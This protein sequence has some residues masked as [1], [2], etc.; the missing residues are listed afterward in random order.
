M[1]WSLL[2]S[3]P[4]LAA[5]AD[6]ATTTHSKTTNYE[7]PVA[8]GSVLRRPIQKAQMTGISGN[9]W[10]VLECQGPPS[11]AVTDRP[12]T[13]SRRYR[14][15][16]M[17]PLEPVAGLAAL[18]GRAIEAGHPGPRRTANNGQRR[19]QALQSM[20]LVGCRPA[21]GG[22][23][24]RRVGD[25]AA[26]QGAPRLPV[27]GHGSTPGRHRGCCRRPVPRRG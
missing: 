26:R 5:F 2:S 14:R 18:V 16:G 27:G 7:P 12:P 11:G 10:Q 6:T 20:I 1:G 19:K 3:L 9:S 17:R 24:A 21:Q 13:V 15:T 22:L 23:T 25:S 8:T 4:G